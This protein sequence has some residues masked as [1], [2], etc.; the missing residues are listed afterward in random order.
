MRCAVNHFIFQ[1]W[2]WRCGA[3]WLWELVF[4]CV[5]LAWNTLFGHLK[6]CTISG[7]HFFPKPKY[8]KIFQ[9]FFWLFFRDGKV[10]SCREETWRN[11][12]RLVSTTDV[13]VI[14]LNSAADFPTSLKIWIPHPALYLGRNQF[15]QSRSPSRRLEWKQARIPTPPAAAGYAAP[16]LTWYNLPAWSSPEASLL[17]NWARITGFTHLHGP[18]FISL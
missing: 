17:L 1:K 7:L 8:D 3:L 16:I 15:H 4:C 10:I 13:E 9:P 2:S 18:R 5:I 12:A 6:P 14:A 11:N